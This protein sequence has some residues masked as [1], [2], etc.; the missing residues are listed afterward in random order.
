MQEDAVGVAGLVHQFLGDLEGSQQFDPFRDLVLFAHGGPDVGIEGVRA[1]EGRRIVSALD[2]GAGLLGH[3][4]AA[5]HDL[6]GRPELLG[7]KA[8]V[9]HAQLG[10]DI[11]QAVSDIVAG[12]AAEDQLAV[13]NG[14]IYMLFHG[15]DV[16]Q[17]LGGMIHVGEAVEHGHAGVFG[18]V[19]HHLLLVAPVFDAVEQA[20]QHLG[21]VGQRFLF[22]HLRGFGI[23]EGDAGAFVHGRHFKGAAGAGGGL[24]EQQHDVLAPQQV[25]LDALLLFTLQLVGQIQQVAYFL[26][27]EIHDAQK[28]APFQTN[29]HRCLLCL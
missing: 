29:A 5:G 13:G 1:L 11:H 14:L 17:G 2:D 9:M 7:A 15:H 26:G 25:V 28:A 6:V 8:H 4:G 22:A 27:R 24:F 20:A 3:L 21:A 12:I 10:A 16:G 19:F 18:Q 23:Q